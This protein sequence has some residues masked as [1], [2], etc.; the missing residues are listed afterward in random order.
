MADI[1]KKC[2][3]VETEVTKAVA[4]VRKT[5]DGWRKKM[6]EHSKKGGALLRLAKPNMTPKEKTDYKKKEKELDDAGKKAMTE[7]GKLQ[8]AIELQAGD[9]RRLMDEVD[10]RMADLQRIQAELQKLIDR[11]VPGLKQALQAEMNERHRLLIES[12]RASGM[13]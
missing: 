13:V 7:I 12:L 5:T 6:E 2:K 4:D 11:V 1:V 3:S 9:G 10:R 8:Q